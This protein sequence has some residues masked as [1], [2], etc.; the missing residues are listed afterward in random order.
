[1]KLSQLL[2]NC[3]YH[4]V[5]TWGVIS[6]KK[7]NNY[8][9]WHQPYETINHQTTID[10]FTWCVMGTSPKSLVAFV[11]PHSPLAQ[12]GR[13]T[14]TVCNSSHAI[15][16]L[17]TLLNFMGSPVRYSFGVTALAKISSRKAPLHGAC[18]RKATMLPTTDWKTESSYNGQCAVPDNL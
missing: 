18:T 8:A 9:T 4:R 3:T 14:I 12:S 15:L 1:M 11:G 2:Q 13:G 10:V 17:Q 5:T 7:T 6:T 16:N